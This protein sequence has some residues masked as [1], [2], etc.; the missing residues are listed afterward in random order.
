MLLIT[1]LCTFTKRKQYR[2][3][4]VGLGV[5]RQPRPT[6]YTALHNSTL[7]VQYIHN[8]MSTARHYPSRSQEKSHLG[9]C[10]F[11]HINRGKFSNSRKPW[12]LPLVVYILFSLTIFIRDVWRRLFHYLKLPIGP[13]QV[14]SH[15]PY[16][17]RAYKVVYLP[18]N[19]SYRYPRV[20]FELTPSQSLSTQRQVNNACA[21]MANVIS[22]KAHQQEENCWIS[23]PTCADSLQVAFRPISYLVIKYFSYLTNFAADNQKKLNNGVS[24]TRYSLCCTVLLKIR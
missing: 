9:T 11:T 22:I 5:V 16:Y 24:W 10:I 3:A 1:P 21:T 13:L 2:P 15:R 20:N 7:I 14:F 8:A 18:T 19:D 23:I 17:C 4:I 6:Y 12:T